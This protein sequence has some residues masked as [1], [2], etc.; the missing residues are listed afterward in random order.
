MTIDRRG[1]S[2]VELL[3]VIAII[4]VLIGLLLPAV[5]TAREAGRRV[6]CANNMKQIGLGLHNYNQVWEHFPQG[7]IYSPPGGPY[8]HSWWVPIFPYLEQRF[9]NSNL[10]DSAGTSSQWSGCTAWG[11]PINTTLLNH[12]QFPFMRCPSSPLPAFGY[13]AY[14]IYNGPMI[15]ICRSSYVGISGSANPPAVHF[16][17]WNANGYPAGE[18]SD[19]ISYNGILPHNKSVAAAQVTDGLSNTMMVAEQSDYCTNVPSWCYWCPSATQ[20]DCSSDGGYAFIAGFFFDGNPRIYNLTTV[21]GHINDRNGQAPGVSLNG[22]WQA[23]N[24]PLLSPHLG[25]ITVLYADGSVHYL[26]DTLNIQVLY[27]LADI[28][29]GS[30]DAPDVQ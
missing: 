20:A 25:G 13:G 12:V 16:S 5:Q 10:F 2:L 28:N 14:Q 15:P 22:S 27:H 17:S 30:T 19:L 18:N 24:N 7:C 1:F 3:V 21:R 26:P 23:T 4:G 9:I 6:Q 8:T 11:N 29:D